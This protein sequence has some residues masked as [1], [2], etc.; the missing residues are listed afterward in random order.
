M[1]KDFR[2]PR[3][4]TPKVVTPIPNMGVDLEPMGNRPITLDQVGDKLRKIEENIFN[5]LGHEKCNPYIW[6]SQHLDSLMREVKEN[7]SQEL[8][9]KIMAMPDDIIPVV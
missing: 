8:F 5:Y 4:E 7:P 3:Q 2:K 6:K 1:P 9:A